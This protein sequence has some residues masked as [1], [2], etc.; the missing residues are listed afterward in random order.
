M[1][2]EFVNGNGPET[3]GPAASGHAHAATSDLWKCLT[4]KRYLLRPLGEKGSGFLPDIVLHDNSVSS[5]QVLK[6]S[7]CL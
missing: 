3:D 6:S 4:T 7:S 2:A 1:N 5:S